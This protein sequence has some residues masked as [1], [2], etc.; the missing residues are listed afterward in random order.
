MAVKDLSSFL[1]DDALEF[2]IGG[3]TY[4]VESPDAKTGLFLSSLANIGVNAAGGGQVSEADLEKLDLDD[5]EE[6]DFMKMVLGD[7]LDELI[8]DG[9]SWVKIQKLSRYCFIAFAIGVEA[10]DDAQASGTLSGEAPA[11]NRAARRAGSRGAAT[12]TKR[13]A[14][15]AGTTS[16][17]P[18][19][20]KPRAKA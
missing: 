16:T 11:P 8:F 13:R 6:R 19:A 4:R 15:T 14:S 18:P 17:K 12:T 1:D 5:V 7:T 10:A 9:V 20:R 3:K 2:P